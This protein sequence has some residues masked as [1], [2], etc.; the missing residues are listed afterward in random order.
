MDPLTIS[1]A[2]VGFG[3]GMFFSIWVLGKHYDTVGKIAI[4][5]IHKNYLECL[6]TLKKDYEE[7]IEEFKY[8]MIEG[9]KEDDKK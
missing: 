9:N 1:A 7:K 8:R 6:D 3:L 4:D 2:G 5:E